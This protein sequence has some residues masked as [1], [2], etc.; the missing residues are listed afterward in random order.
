MGE[1]CKPSESY[2]HAAVRGLNEELDILPH[3]ISRIVL[4]NK[5]PELFEIA[6]HNDRVDYQW[7]S[8]FLV[9]LNISSAHVNLN[10][11]SESSWVP[12]T[13][14]RGWLHKCDQNNGC[15]SCRPAAIRI[16]TR[17]LSPI[18]ITNFAELH[19]L[20]IDRLTSLLPLISPDHKIHALHF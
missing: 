1:H 3:Q 6:Y 14:L 8:T 20:F 9:I 18:S 12:L 11:N 19:L 4:L 5:Y 17:G 2:R 16:S 13:S 7:T 10:E 15:V